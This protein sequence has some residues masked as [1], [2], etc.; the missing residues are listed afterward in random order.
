MKKWISRGIVLAMII[1]MMVPMPAAA[2]S[3]KGG[4]KVKAVET[5]GYNENGVM[6]LRE[7][8]S[9]KFDSKGNIE[10]SQFTTD[11]SHFG[12]IAWG[13]NTTVTTFDNRYKGKTL[14]SVT[15]KDASGAVLYKDTY[16]KGHVVKSVSS[17]F[18]NESGAVE[19]T[20]SNYS[21]TKKGLPSA[22]ITYGAANDGS[23]WTWSATYALSTKKGLV[24]AANI[25]TA[26]TH[27]FSDGTTDSYADRRYAYYNDKGLV[28]EYGYYNDKGVAVPWSRYSYQMKKGRVTM[29][30]ELVYDAAK[31]TWS[32]G[33]IYKFIYSSANESKADYAYDINY[34]LHV[35]AF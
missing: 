4:K 19:N 34:E 21:Y 6:Q 22:E 28:T 32:T 27:K 24:R 29:A 25:N 1:A 35:P 12:P 17:Y 18:Q 15:A 26:M 3:S 16:K 23:S 8:I 31:G 13:G 5:Y 20:V 33:N 11:F 9:Y 7:K 10:E 2:A 14:K 30:T